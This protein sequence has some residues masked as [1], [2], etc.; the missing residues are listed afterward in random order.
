MCQ[1]GKLSE[2]EPQGC[3]RESFAAWSTSCASFFATETLLRIACKGSA[4]PRGCPLA[5]NKACAFVAKHATKHDGMLLTPHSQPSRPCIYI[6]DRCKFIV[7]VITASLL[8][9]LTSHPMVAG[10]SPP[11]S[12]C[13]SAVVCLHL[14]SRSPLC[15]SVAGAPVTLLCC[16]C[17]IGEAPR[18]CAT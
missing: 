17:C 8:K 2:Q 5:C 14:A 12:K 13:L 4:T 16:L 9:A 3:Q 18:L 7:I 1:R 6:W 10:S 11:L 15:P